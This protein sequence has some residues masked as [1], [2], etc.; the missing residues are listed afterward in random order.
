MTNSISDGNRQ[1]LILLTNHFPYGIHESFLA[2]EIPYLTASFSKVIIV[3]RDVKSQGT[4]PT[5]GATVYRIDPTSHWKEKCLTPWLFIKHA[6][7]ILGYVN[8]EVNWL[9][10]RNKKLTLRIWKQMF[11]TLT[12]A[13]ITAHHVNGIIE[14][15]HFSGKIALY[16]YWLS[17]SALATTFVAGNN[18]SLK[19]IS[20]A[21]GGDVYEKRTNLGYL[22]FRRTLAKNLNSIYAISEHGAQH[23]RRQLS[24]NSSVKVARLGTEYGGKSPLK[25]S[26]TYVVVSCS[27][28]VTVKRLNLLISA[29]QRIEKVDIHWIHIGNGPLEDSIK[30]I[31]KEKLGPK[32]NMTYT[33]K[34]A[35]ANTD[36]I[37][38]YK[39][40]Y[41]D[42]FVNTSR[43]EGIPVT[44]MEAQSFGIPI[45]GPKTGGV[46]EV[47]TGG[48]GRLYDVHATPEIIAGL[49]SEVLLLPEADYNM[50]RQLAF[51]NWH[52]RY[53]AANNF[54]TFVAEISKL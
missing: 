27:F 12:K 19:K 54:S 53:N 1:T 29:L 24:N 2:S 31:A 45:V 46:P 15:N 17:S 10:A 28:M 52:E 5:H 11:H 41:V 23:I 22:S 21:H 43:S 44:M 51:Q 38:F 42:V 3:A 8:D 33:F 25:T 40:Q 30:A 7:R 48:T 9:R 49:I 37:E 47:I 26:P 35:L 34:G 16:S 4:R 36:I 6:R 32:T 20:R 50:M 13:L 14:R 39:N 18:I